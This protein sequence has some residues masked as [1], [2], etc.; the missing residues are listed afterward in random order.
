MAGVR[1]GDVGLTST[2][3]A[4]EAVGSMGLCREHKR[5]RRGGPGPVPRAARG[6]GAELP[7]RS[8]GEEG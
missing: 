2:S 8:G 4:T 3:T 1:D 7:V 6:V 5:L